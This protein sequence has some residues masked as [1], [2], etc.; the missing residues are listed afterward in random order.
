MP[1]LVAEFREEHDLLP[2]SEKSG[3]PRDHGSSV[4]E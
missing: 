1:S 4:G 3:K 2:L